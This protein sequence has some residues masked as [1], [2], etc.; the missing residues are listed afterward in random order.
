M[1][2]RFL[3]QVAADLA[4][5]RSSSRN[6]VERCLYNIARPDGE[7]ART[8][9]QIAATEA[10]TL[11]DGYDAMRA[12]GTSLS[13][14]TGIPISVKDLF[15]VQGQV[16][17][18]GSI[19]LAAE[20]P[21]SRDAPSVARLR[22]A[23]FIVL[24]RTN[25]TEFAFSGLGLNPHYGT[26][27]NPW[28]RRHSRIPGGS[29]SG[30]AVSVCDEMAFAGLGTDTGGSCRIPAAMCGLVG[31]K[32]TAHRVPLLGVY[33]LSPTLDSVGCL[34]SSVSCCEVLYSVLTDEPRS[35]LTHYPLSN[36]KLG[37]PVNHVVDGLCPGVAS[38]FEQA[39]KN[40]ASAGACLTEFRFDELAEIPDLYRDGGL[41]A[42]EA[43]QWHRDMIARNADRYD[44]RVLAR[45]L[46]AQKQSPDDRLVLHKQR[47]DLI[48]RTRSTFER[49]EALLMPTVPI[50]APTLAE[51]ASDEEYTRIN[52]LVLR[53]PS[54]VNILDGC[55]ISVPC[56]RAGEGP[57]GLTIFA[58]GD[59]DRRILSIAG[60]IERLFSEDH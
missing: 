33:P 6:L 5:G 32:P 8:Y 16:T 58:A 4:E 52:A 15:D 44:A 1:S 47:R 10:R 34:A 30:A 22:A 31:L 29:S 24:G 38:S 19:V 49:F 55:A 48:E 51:L 60:A 28:D 42:A 14:W 35:V 26:P 57:V 23:G 37:I 59:S 3:T 12:R 21:A 7:G 39:L 56:H 43:Y 41:P 54:V 25:M 27:R 18:A 11:A 50:L 53:N 20:A 17:K 40:L 46:R 9:L 2:H 13:P 45:I 36:L